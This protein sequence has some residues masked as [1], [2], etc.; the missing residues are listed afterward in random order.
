MFALPPLRY[1]VRMS[2]T[3]TR[4]GT[5]KIGELVRSWRSR[6]RLTQ[7]EF[8]GRADISTKHL[9]FL[10]TGR[11]QP[12]R[13]MVLRLAELLDIP[14]RERNSLLMAAGYAPVFPERALDDPELTLARQ[15]VDM[16]LKGHEPY[17]AIAVNRHW[18]L[19]AANSAVALLLGDVAPALRS[20]PINVFRVSMHPDGFCSRIANYIEW[21]AHALA[22]LRH[23]VE[24]S[25]DAILAEL[26]REVSEYPVPERDASGMRRDAAIGLAHSYAIPVVPLKYITPQGILSF[27]S[28]VTMFGT[29][30]D[31]TLSELAIESMYPA[32]EATAEALRAIVLR[33]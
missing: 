8:A 29:P 5:L 16:V 9:S 1:G 22:R 33:N 12:S 11:A 13:D 6:R 30:I 18:E 25:G 23:Q 26:Y 31:I 7:L 27:F 4:N 21:R 19:V 24:I 15:A 28:T 2:V 20:E 3:L 32:D 14:L 17:P 10:E